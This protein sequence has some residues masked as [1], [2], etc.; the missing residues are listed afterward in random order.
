MVFG[1][2]EDV[3]PCA[4]GFVRKGEPQQLLNTLVTTMKRA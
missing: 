2:P 4:S 3:A 1:M